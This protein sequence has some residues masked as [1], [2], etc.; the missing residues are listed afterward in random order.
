MDSFNR[1]S[2]RSPSFFFSPLAGT[3]EGA[4][5]ILI[6]TPSAVQNPLHSPGPAEKWTGGDN[7]GPILFEQRF[8]K[9]SALFDIY[10]G[11]L[12]ASETL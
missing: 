8:I 1:L 9:L 10:I 11:A 5:L 12:E 2:P 7:L 4:G 3:Y 6:L